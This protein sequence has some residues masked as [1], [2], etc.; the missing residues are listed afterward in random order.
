MPA[1]GAVGFVRVLAWPRVLFGFFLGLGAVGVAVKSFTYEPITLLL[2]A[3]GG[4][5]FQRFVITPLW[6][7]TLRFESTP[8]T[9]SEGVD[10]ATAVTSFN[11]NGE[12]LV[13][14]EVDGQV[15]QVLGRLK[16]A[17]RNLGVVVRAGQRLRVEDVNTANNRCTVS[18][19]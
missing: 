16:Q 9:T 12:G 17:D 14:I 15:V 6:N 18:A 10:E 11:A 13:A 1:H 19:I 8:A 4:L 5:L 3:A 7:L 2:A